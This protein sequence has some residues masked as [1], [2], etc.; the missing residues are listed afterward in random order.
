M[1]RIQYPDGLIAP[2][3][4]TQTD[5]IML[6]TS[7][8]MLAPFAGHAAPLTP[9]FA[10]VQDEAPDT[11]YQDR[12]TAAGED[13]E[14]LMELAAWCKENDRQAQ[15]RE[16]YRKVIG[17]DPDHAAARK[18]LRHHSYDGKWFETYVALSNY[19]R[20]EA[21]RM[22]EEE[23]KVRFGD[24][25]VLQTDV[26]FLR[27]A[28]KKD[29]A[30]AWVNPNDA[31]R[32]AEREKR[33]AD[34]WMMHELTW[35]PPGKSE[36]WTEGSWWVGD[37]WVPTEEADTF[38]SNLQS[39]WQIPGQYFDVWTTG[40]R[41][42]QGS[43]ARYW[44]DLT[45]PDLMRAYGIE[46]DFENNKPVV[47]V[48]KDLTQYN[49]FAAGDQQSVPPAET[50][51][52]SSAHYAFFADALYNPASEPW[53]FLG[54]G[55]CFFDVT[56][57]A[58]WWKQQS[59]RHAAALSWANAIDP[60]WDAVSQA[61]AAKNVQ[62]NIAQFWDEKRAPRWFVYG[63]AV[64]CERYYKDEQADMRSWALENLRSRSGGLRANLEDV[65][66]FGVTP[67]DMEGTNKLMME[68]GAL[69]AFILDGECA[70]VTAAH[71]AF[72]AAMKSGEGV[73]EAVEG[74]QKALLDNEAKL[75]EWGNIPVP[76]ETAAPAEAATTT[77]GG[78]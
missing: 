78:Q 62:T 27:M 6:T 34:G 7:L 31:A 19:K 12:L 26:P 50:E 39:P 22:L 63:V 15:A 54:S 17:I 70:P 51:G 2:R 14:K 45:Y 33:L 30:G 43:W 18:A 35:I 41:D 74:L 1:G 32:A 55:A 58:C 37:K 29:D 21:K 53:E 46:P 64:Y 65:F 28:W 49:T 36:E 57:E 40:P 13:A 66:A 16:V 69:V 48:L 11:E 23:G 60:S 20:A 8:L 9:S 52:L 73:D 56:D 38:H 44:A 25:W 71:E 42:A 75:R 4:S 24:E 10:R 61:I 67:N 72:K 3:L 47:F 5:L 68:A 59:V 76:P 77:E